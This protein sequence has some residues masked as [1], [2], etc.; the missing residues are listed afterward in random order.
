MNMKTLIASAFVALGMISQAGAVTTN[1]IYLTGSTAF[2]GNC[3]NV[4][5]QGTNT[6]GIWDS[7]PQ[8]ATRGNAT[9]SKGNYMLFQGNINGQPYI[10]SCGWSGSEAGIA[11]VAGNNIDNAPYGPLPGA[12]ETFLK[13]DGTVPYTEVASGPAA[14]EL[15][16]SSRQA[17]LAMADTSKAVSLSST[18]PLYD[19][20]KVGIVTFVWVKNYQSAPLAAWTRLSNITHGQINVLLGFPQVAAFFTGNASDTNHYVYP[21][22]RNKGSGTRANELCDSGYGVTKPV[23]Q[24]S[25][26][27][28]PFTGSGDPSTLAEVDNNGY[29]S[30]G[31][32]ANA[33]AVDGSQTATGPDGNPGYLAVGLLG[34]GDAI[35]SANPGNN[36]QT[37]TVAAN[38]LT[39]NGVAESDGAIEEGQY[40]AF[41][42]EHLYGQNGTAGYVLTF[43]NFFKTQLGNSL[44]GSNPAAHSSGIGLQY[45]HAEKQTDTAAPT[46]L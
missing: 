44:G 14:G 4:L 13:T 32:V 2:R 9:F 42:N 7:T 30:G 8:I 19:F 11:S 29:E 25:I 35:K 1:T 27:G 43:G 39:L 5:S 41:G 6:G 18:F 22:G 21:I 46:R 34:C 31:D 26:N 33:L 24:W 28:I 3:F 36:T 17:N 40:S 12:P 10:I 38:W 37:L 16:S 45:M 20:G 23:V 15:E